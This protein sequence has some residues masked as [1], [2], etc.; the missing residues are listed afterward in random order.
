MSSISHEFYFVRVLFRTISIP[1][2]FYSVQF[3]SAQFY[4]VQFYFFQFYNVAVLFRAVLFRGSSPPC[5]FY[6][7]APPKELP[8]IELSEIEL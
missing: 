3:Y 5:K 1:Y 7:V 6:T 4:S 8:G 2:E